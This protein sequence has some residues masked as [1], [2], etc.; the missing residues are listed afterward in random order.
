MEVRTI[1]EVHGA[2]RKSVMLSFCL[3]MYKVSGKGEVFTG[4]LSGILILGLTNL[5]SSINCYEF[6]LGKFSE[7]STYLFQKEI[8]LIVTFL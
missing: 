3:G 5:F 2:A 1:L 7:I 6:E 4:W 8:V